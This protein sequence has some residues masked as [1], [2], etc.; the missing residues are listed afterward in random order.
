MANGQGNDMTFTV[1]ASDIPKFSLCKTPAAAV[2]TAAATD[3][4]FAVIQDVGTAT[5]IANF[6]LSGRTTMI[7]GAA[8]AQGVALMSDDTGK[9]ITHDGT[10]TKPVVGISRTACGADTEYF[11]AV[12]EIS[13]IAGPA[14]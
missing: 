5:E 13:K 12:L 10:S 7:G 11:E 14:A 3:D 2:V 6:R 4:C 8:I 1:G 9:V